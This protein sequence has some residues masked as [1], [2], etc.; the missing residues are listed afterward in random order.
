MA[1]KDAPN[2]ASSMGSQVKFHINVSLR[3]LR[4]PYPQ[5]GDIVMR[6]KD[7]EIVLAVAE[8]KSFTKAAEK[9]H[10]SQPAISLA[11]KRFEDSFGEKIFERSGSQVRLAPAA[12]QA[13]WAVKRI[14][15]IFE[16]V[17]HHGVPEEHIRIGIPALLSGCSMT[18]LVDRLRRLGKK[19][20]EFEFLASEEIFHRDDLDASVFVQTGSTSG[21]LDLSLPVRWI[22]ARNGVFIY[23]K[24]ERS[25]WDVAMRRA[26]QCGLD[27]DRVVEVNSCFHAYQLAADGAGFSPCVIGGNARFEDRIIDDMPELPAIRLGILAQDRLVASSVQRV[28]GHERALALAG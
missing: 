24:Q 19:G 14:H 12:E 28:L 13:L 10:L 25:L 16:S 26:R 1:G 9:L 5:A 27:I 11:V 15:D 17:I 4:Q 22:G 3:R 2:R 18:T 20:V 21:D 7:C 23:S 8:F 6:M